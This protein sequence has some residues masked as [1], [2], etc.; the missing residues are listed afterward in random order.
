MEESQPSVTVEDSTF[1]DVSL[2]KRVATTS[3]RHGSRSASSNVEEVITLSDAEN[4]PWCYVVNHGNNN[5]YVMISATKNYH[6]VL[7][8]SDKGNFDVNDI[9]EAA[10]FYIDGYLHMHGF[11]MV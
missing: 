4:K 11:V 1:V 3:N 8:W 6:P 10:Q 9:P 2:A 7:M 5:G